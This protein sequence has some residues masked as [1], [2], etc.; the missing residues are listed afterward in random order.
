VNPDVVEA[1]DRLQASGSLTPEQARL[2]GRV[3]RRELVG[4]RAELRLVAYAGVLLA[5]AGVA[6]LLRE[7]LDR[8]GPLA[9]ACA[10]ALASLAC[11]AWVESRAPAFAWG[12]VASPHLALDYV[13]LLGALLA[14]A[15][16]AFVE[17]RFTPLGDAWPW[18]LLLVAALYA[19][20]AFR[21]DSR[22]V[23]S[24]ALSSFAAWRGVSSSRLQG[25]F[26]LG[27]DDLVRANAAGCALLFLATGAL[28]RAR[29]RK[30]H[31]EPVATHVG[32]LLL[33]GTAASA[34]ATPDGSSWALALVALA[35]VA[36]LVGY[37][38]RRFSLMAIA[39]VA[40]YVGVSALAVRAVHD[41]VLVFW[42]FALTPLAVVS[43]LFVAHRF[44]REP[45]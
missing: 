10:L 14:A 1:V 12:E 42:W 7:N 28:L 25:A 38:Q 6:E 20:L 30:A 9:I 43:L 45:E 22:V 34:L 37:L 40:A 15:D 39:L 17:A 33:L 44:L 41:D 35:G 19:L 31:F 32:W 16:L 29:R 5:T 4:V 36:G 27:S 2:F 3:A 11:L 23:F 24:L 18:H 13:L 21:Y 26:W 8:I